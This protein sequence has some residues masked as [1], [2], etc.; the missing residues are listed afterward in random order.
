[1]TG[2]SDDCER[3]KEERGAV[4]DCLETEF[5]DDFSADGGR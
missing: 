3:E 2:A 4:T 1:M 5:M